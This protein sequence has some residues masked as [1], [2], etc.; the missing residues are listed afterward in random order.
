[1]EGRLKKWEEEFTQI[2]E[3]ME[4][5]KLPDQCNTKEEID[6]QL[7]NL[8]VIMTQKNDLRKILEAETLKVIDQA[9]LSVCLK[10]YFLSDLIYHLRIELNPFIPTARTD[11]SCIEFNPMFVL[12]LSE[13]HLETLVAHET[14]HPALGHPWRLMDLEEKIT[15]NVIMVA[16]FAGDY[17][18]NEILSN[19]GYD[20]S[21]GAL[22]DRKYHGKSMEEIYEDLKDLYPEPPECDQNQECKGESD[23]S[24]EQQDGSSQG[25]SKSKEQPS[26]GSGKDNQDEGGSDDDQDSSG[27]DDDQDGQE[28]EKEKEQPG[29][30]DE[31]QDE[32]SQSNQKNQGQ[33]SSHS[34]FGDF[35]PPSKEKDE[36]EQTWKSRTENA[37]NNAQSEGSMPANVVEV[38]KSAWPE[39]FPQAEEILRQIISGHAK[40]DYRWFPPNR[41][42]I[43]Q[44]IYLPS[45]ISDELDNL[46][47]CIDTSGSV[48]EPQLKKFFSKTNGIL[49]TFQQMTCY[50]ILCDSYI[51]SVKRYTRADLPIEPHIKGRGGTDFRPPF[52]LLDAEGILPS[53]L[54]YFTDMQCSS[55]PD[56]PG[57]P[58][59]WAYLDGYDEYSSKTNEMFFKPRPYGE[60]RGHGV[61]PFGVVIDVHDI[62]REME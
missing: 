31:E 57:Y 7:L 27:G 49:E 39:E 34:G 12:S 52:K 44:G 14:L 61:N 48:R 5:L 20:L 21:P 42:F 29:N 56:D 58:V 25:N 45:N 60:Y 22:Y 62:I 6:Q 9:R 41:R 24:G 51:H 43:H 40:N 32:D 8:G 16:N 13:S 4:R 59:I 10:D 3:G 37:V 50:L 26:D 11:G 30:S 33:S 46:V 15:Q 35:I 19:C 28:E 55:F 38:I 47:I 54:I 23:G 2:R 1:M 53:C 17:V 36:L 18:I